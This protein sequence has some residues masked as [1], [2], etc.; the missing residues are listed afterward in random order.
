MPGVPYPAEGPW[1]PSPNGGSGS[2]F[3]GPRAGRWSSSHGSK[4]RSSSDYS[5]YNYLGMS[6]RPGRETSRLGRAGDRFGSSAT[7]SRMVSGEMPIRTGGSTASSADFVRAEDC[8][9][10]VGGH[11]TNVTTLGHL[12][13]A[14]R[15]DHARRALH[16]QQRPRRLRAV[17]RP[18]ARPSRITTPG[19]RLDNILSDRR[20]HHRR[21]AVSGHRRGLQHGRRHSRFAP[22]SLTIKTASQGVPDD[23]QALSIR[24]AR[25]LRSRDQ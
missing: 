7:A 14:R 19:Q 21:V 17:A 6:R 24:R 18:R 4:A 9:T 10:F 12:F 16:S 5:G 1:N 23:R 13:R 20:R 3:Q 8:L 15:S 2:H 25:C 11:A 22:G